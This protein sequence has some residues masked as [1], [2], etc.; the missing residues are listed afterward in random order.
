MLSPAENQEP[1]PVEPMSRSSLP[2]IPTP[3][4]QRWREFRI[5]VLPLVV[6]SL[7]LGVIV[8]LWR[9]A[10]MG[11]YLAGVA[12]GVRS[13]VTSRQVGLIQQ[14][15]VQPY[16]TVEAGEPLAI[17]QPRDPQA[18]LGLLQSEFQIARLRLQPSVAERNVMNFE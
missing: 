7:L 17:L 14:L 12:E 9:E 8:L 1:V 10:G 6:F 3:L 15:R 4:A 16:Q 2:P 13:V 5:N 11:G 18:E